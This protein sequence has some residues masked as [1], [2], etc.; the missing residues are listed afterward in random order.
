M[1]EK[2][3]ALSLGEKIIVIAAVALFIIGFLPWYHAG[4]RV[5]VGGVTVADI[6]VNRNAWQSPGA[7]WSMLAVIIG[8]AMAAVILARQMAA[9]GTLPDQVGGLSWPQ[10]FL[11]GSVVAAVCVLIKLL[12]HSGDLGLGFF[13]GIIAV[14]ALVVGG[15][16]VYTGGRAAQQLR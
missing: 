6:S 12:N 3:N 4:G 16:L 13:L 8:L 10:I 7:I 11:G 15:Y 9:A 2:F 1:I 5:E 14:A